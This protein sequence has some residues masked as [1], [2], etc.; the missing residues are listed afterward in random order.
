MAM[1]KHQHKHKHH[2]FIM[3]GMLYTYGCN[4]FGQL[5]HGDLEFRTTPEKL[6][7]LTNV[8]SFYIGLN[9]TVVIKTDG[10][11]FGFG[12][13]DRG[14]LGHVD[15]ECCSVPIPISQKTYLKHAMDL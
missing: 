1:D 15:L 7:F 12:S 14:Q 3:E 4:V 8:K 9:F 11:C 13:N 2:A 6:K 10:S 5:G